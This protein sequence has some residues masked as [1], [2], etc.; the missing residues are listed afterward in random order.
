[1]LYHMYWASK[2]GL[3]L[4]AHPV[5]QSLE[6]QLSS[7]ARRHM[8][9]VVPPG[10]EELAGSLPHFL[11]EE[12]FREAFTPIVSNHSLL[13]N[14]CSKY[15]AFQRELCVRCFVEWPIMAQET[16]FQ[17]GLQCESLLFVVRGVITYS[18]AR[19]PPVTGSIS[20]TAW[21]QVM[22]G[23]M[24]ETGEVS[25]SSLS[26]GDWLCEHCL[27]TTWSYLGHARTDSGADM[28]CLGRDRVR[29]LAQARLE[30]MD[31]IKREP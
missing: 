11:Y 22:P 18:K 30:K 3:L 12:F 10:K 21:A 25:A 14:L 24:G 28:L 8:S 1:M 6:Q 31:K 2:R 20:N 4:Q 27:W 17:P 13:H 15:S 7:Y 19:L 29:E 9:R 16:L 26:Q 5:P 23:S